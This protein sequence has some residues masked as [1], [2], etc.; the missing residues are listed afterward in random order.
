MTMGQKILIV[1]DDL[2]FRNYLYQVLKYDY[3]VVAVPGPLE[4]IDEI[5][6][7]SYSLMITDLRMPDMDG[8]ALVEKVHKELDPAIMVIVITAFE[9]DW[10]VDVAMSSNVFRYL[11]KGAFMPSELKQ[12]VEKALEVQ[13]SIVSLEEYKRRAN[14]SETLYKDVFDNSTD[15]LFVTD[16]H[17]RPLA[18]NKRFEEMSGYSLEELKDKTLFEIIWEEDRKQA[19]QAFNSQIRG[20]GPGSIKVNLVKKDGARRHVKVWARLVKDVQGTA[21]SVFCIARDADHDSEQ[22][23]SGK[24]ELH[25]RIAE[26]TKELDLVEKKFR[27][28]TAH[29]KDMIV[30]LDGRCRCEYVNA[31]VERCIGYAA[32]PLM[33][34]EF[35]W[36]D[37]IHPDDR[38]ILNEV[39]DLIKARVSS[40]SGEVKVQAKSGFMLHLTFCTFMEY[41][42]EGKL[43]GI[44]IV[45]EDITQQKVAEQ[46]LKNANL[47]IHEFNERLSNGFSQKI[48]ALRESEERYK[49]IVEDSGDIIFS[50][51][52]NARIVYMNRTGL[53][54]VNM[55]KE[56]V[57]GVHCSTF[58]ADDPSKKRLDEII[59]LMGKDIYPEPLDLIIDTPSGRKTYR[60]TLTIIGKKNMR[61]IVCVAK[62]ISDEIVKN[63]RL[64][65]LANIEHYSADAIIG[66]DRS[67]LILSWNEGASMIFGWSEDEAIGK[68]VNFMVPGEGLKEAEEM[69]HEVRTKGLVKDYETKR[70]T[71]SGQI[72]DASIT[73]TALKDETGEI[74]G[75]SSIMKDLTEK[76]KMEAALIQSERLA[77][78]GKLSASIAHE[79]NNPLYGIRSCLN[80]VEN[81]ERGKIDH[82]FVKLA[83][84]ETDRIADLIRN[85][86]TFYL[87]NEGTAR[88]V[89]IHETLREV[90]ILNKRYLEE[91]MVKMVF[92]P[93]G[94]LSIECVPE[95]IKQVFINII[96]N[97]VEAMPEGGELH[98]ETR[99]SDDRQSVS[100]VFRDTGVGISRDDLPQVFDMFYTKKPM[101]KGVGLGLSVSYGIVK[102]HGGTMEIESEEGRGTTVVVTLPVNTAFARQMKLDLVE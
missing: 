92:N 51:D 20:E 95:Q 102:R 31:E 16:I 52:G 73:L 90:F 4:A 65:L 24:A 39:K 28:F 96:T 86:K 55:K 66:L 60:A 63:K 84:K 3:D 75:F 35:P 19:E 72:L 82:Q 6:K 56:D 100:V 42:D 18:A 37:I 57:Y 77:A 70:N 83:I 76:K 54:T 26:K 58:I 94:V 93:E 47:K 98:V 89:D 9:D 29:T 46:E 74:F 11:R 64:Q 48:K 40:H 88:G 62:D 68:N 91:N 49:N 85:M 61:E 78:M 14:I 12:N 33:G 101:V 2:V 79:I 38:H 97:A 50:L 80:H 41:E 36:G 17:L 43:S 27:R 7:N 13:G 87:P 15:A 71:K 21:N 99:E 32:G 69:L 22:T 25:L 1:E 30:W 8:R 67:G 53:Q 23:V 5:R 34:K 45:A 10:P 44:T 81:A 59:E